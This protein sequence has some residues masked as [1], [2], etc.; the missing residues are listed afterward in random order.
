LNV[1]TRWEIS[2]QSEERRASSGFKIRPGEENGSRIYQL[3]LHE[4]S[5]LPSDI[6]AKN[7][8]PRSKV[9][10]DGASESVDDNASAG[11][12]RNVI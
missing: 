11:K 10:K 6:P 9:F 2:P 5:L 3:L 4:M 1:H 8:V 12:E 7:R